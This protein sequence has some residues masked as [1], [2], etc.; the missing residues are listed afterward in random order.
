MRKR[1]FWI[2]GVCLTISFKITPIKGFS[3]FI[4]FILTPF[5]AQ[6]IF[7]KNWKTPR[8]RWK[9]T[10]TWTNRLWISSWPFLKSAQGKTV[11]S[12]C[13]I[14]LYSR[15]ERR[16]NELDGESEKITEL[17]NYLDVKK[18]EAIESSFNDISK[19]FALVFSKVGFLAKILKN[20]K[21]VSIIDFNSIYLSE[22]TNKW[23]FF[24][25]YFLRSLT[26]ILKEQNVGFILT[27]LYTEMLIQI[28]FYKKY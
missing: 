11:V 21:K 13:F 12:E 9:T 1:R 18:F 27:I 3:L 17:V 24:R 16:R 25:A 7:S 14:W 5:S 28:L 23:A 22:E 2:S 8:K 10:A 15:L 19:N 4:F 20:W 26:H 6:S